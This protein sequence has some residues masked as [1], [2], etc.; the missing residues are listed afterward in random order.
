MI[1]EEEWDLASRTTK[2]YFIKKFKA[3]VLD[4]VKNKEAEIQEVLDKKKYS[5]D[6]RSFEASINKR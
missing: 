1:S 2:E 5:V 4:W 3:T 6:C